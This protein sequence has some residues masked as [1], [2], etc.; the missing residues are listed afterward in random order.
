MNSLVSVIVPVFN[1][2]KYLPKCI[3]SILNQSYKYIEVILI[4]DGSTDSSEDIC[5]KYKLKDNRIRVINKINGGLS[6]ARNKG[7]D[8]AKGK[9]VIF[10]DSD[11]FIDKDMIKNLLEVAITQNA[12]IVQGG[13]QTVYE[14]GKIKRKY[15]YNEMVFDTKTKILDAYF[16]QDLINVIVCNKLY[17]SKLF[18]NLRMMEGRNQ[19]D[20]IIMPQLLL[21]TK[22]IINVSGI[23]YNYL[24]RDISIMNSKFSEKKLDCI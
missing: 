17:K 1:V 7:L 8:V 12:D 15:E 22:K 13:F 18:N 20:Y 23:Y 2:E 21:N 6:S 5:N 24:Q 11:D 4:N 14:D 19:E 9:Y 16:K 3:E 10:V